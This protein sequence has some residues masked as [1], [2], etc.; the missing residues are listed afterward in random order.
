M[1]NEK[2]V[3]SH[4]RFVFP[5][6]HPLGR[7]SPGQAAYPEPDKL[8]DMFHHPRPRPP[9]CSSVR[10]RCLN[11]NGI[12]KTKIQVQMRPGAPRR[13][14]QLLKSKAGDP[15]VMMHWTTANLMATIRGTT[16]LKMEDCVWLAASQ[17][18]SVLI[19][20]YNSP[21]KPLRTARR[22]Q[23]KPQEGQ[24]RHQQCRRLGAHPAV[25]IEKAAGV[26]STPR[27]LNQPTQLIGGHISMASER[28]G[29]CEPRQVKEGPGP[30][31]RGPERIPTTR[32]FRP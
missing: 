3:F 19:V 8:I 7:R 2:L 18:P 6:G 12:V 15:Y 29:D 30:R 24:R 20:P 27:P 5:V 14:R 22:C 16:Q 17:D 32:T 25:R 13:I 28:C 10:G 9:I 23:G 1:K 31:H 26:R 4:R 21:T 11:K